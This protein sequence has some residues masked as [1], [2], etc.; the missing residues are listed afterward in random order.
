M[1]QFFPEKEVIASWPSYEELVE[2]DCGAFLHN[3]ETSNPDR[4]FSF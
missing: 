4:V 2:H 3:P 1:N